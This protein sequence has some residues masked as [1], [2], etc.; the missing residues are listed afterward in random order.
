MGVQRLDQVEA[1]RLL[2]G[3][4]TVGGLS[5]SF[6]PAPDRQCQQRLTQLLVACTAACRLLC[7]QTMQAE[8]LCH[9]WRHLRPR[10]WPRALCLKQITICCLQAPVDADL[11][12]QE[13]IPPRR[14]TLPQL[15][16]E[17]KTFNMHTTGRKAELVHRLETALAAA[18][19]TGQAA[20]HLPS[21]SRPAVASSSAATQQQKHTSTGRAAA[22]TRPAAEESD[23]QQAVPGQ[24]PAAA[25]RAAGRQS[26]RKR[27]QPAG[28]PAAP[29]ASADAELRP[30]T[31]ALGEPVTFEV[32]A[33][34][35]GLLEH[36]G[37]S[38]VSGSKLLHLAKSWQALSFAVNTQSSVRVAKRST[39]Q[40][41]M[42]ARHAT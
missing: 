38:A 27:K 14:M 21:S 42:L 9:T 3:Q 22:G 26:E 4:D 8:S 17:L 24:R 19:D 12:A 20:D 5:C 31:A 18:R 34:F 33:R 23:G 7:G 41:R 16:A 10:R 2:D 13:P 39:C 6:Q 15:K 1:G 37:C 29:S 11:A 28:G 30:G 25:A 40:L 35:P 36:A 32:R